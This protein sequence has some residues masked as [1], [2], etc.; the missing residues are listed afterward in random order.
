MA[1]LSI[2]GALIGWITNV[3]A[4]KLMFRPIQAFKIPGIGYEIQ[5]LI[6]KRRKDVA[7]SI[8][9]T[10]EKELISIE[11][12]LER[13]LES[14]NKNDMLFTI[15]TKINEVITQKLPSILPKSLKE[16]I[17]HYVN[18]M[19]D[20]EAD[21][22]IDQMIDKLTHKATTSVKIGEMVEQKINEFDLLKLEEIIISIAQKELKHIEYIGAILGFF[23]GVV[24]ALII[25]VI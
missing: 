16:M 25:Y 4:I 22:F 9:E 17:I 21:S 6:P 11:E 15:K 2:I 1:I 18:N 20:E 23:I 12:I 8:G 7:K 13:M 14:Q 24:Q 3:L 5:G 19:I 10:V